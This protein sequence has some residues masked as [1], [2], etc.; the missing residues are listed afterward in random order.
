MDSFAGSFFTLFQTVDNL[1]KTLCIALASSLT[2]PSL[3]AITLLATDFPRN[4]SSSEF[5]TADALLQ[6]ST[7]NFFSGGGN[8]LG[9]N[10]PGAAANLVNAYNDDEELVIDFENEA[11]LSGFHVRWTNTTLTITGLDADPVATVGLSGGSANWSEIRKE[12]TLTLPWD[13]GTERAISFANPEATRG[14]NLTFQFSGVQATFTQ[15]EYEEEVLPLPEPWVH[16]SFDD[17]TVTGTSLTDL[18]SNGHTGTL[19][20]S[21]SSPT[22]SLSGLFGEAFGF[23]GDDDPDGVV[24]IPAGIVPSGASAR[25]FSLWFN[26]ASSVGQSKLFGY[27]SSAAGKAFDIGLEG[28]GVRLRHFGGFVTFGSGLDFD[29]VDAGWH[30]LAVRVNEGA[31]TFADVELFLD[32]S[33]ILPQSGG[34]TSVV[35]DTASALFALGSSATPGAAQGFDGLLDEFRIYNSALQFGQIRDLAEAPPRPAILTFQASPQ[36]RVPANSSVTLSWT[37]ENTTSLILDPGGIDVTGQTSLVVTPSEKTTYTLTASDN[38]P[39]SASQALTVA[40]GEEPFPN[41]IVFFLDDFSWSDWEQNGAS[42]GSVFH[43]TPNMNRMASEGVYCSNGY[44]AT[45]VCSPTRG[46]LMSGQA[47][48]LNKVTDWISGSGDNGQTVREAEWLQNLPTDLPNWPRTLADCGYRSIHVGK[49]HLGETDHPSS[50][51]LNHG[52]Q[53][54]I[55]G[56]RF[57]TPPAPERYFASANGFSALPNLGP[58]I[59]PQGSYLTDVLTEQAVA[60]IQDAASSNTAFAMYFSHYAVHTPI[61]APAATVAKYQAKLDNNPGMDWQGHT[62]PTYAAMVEHIDL[63]LGA[64]LDTLQDPDGD[65]LTDDS[66]AENTLVILTAD[67]GG[68]MSVTSNRPLRNG[69][70]GNYDGGV[71]E[72]WIFWQPGNLAPRVEEEPII[73]YDL[74]PTILSKAGITTPDNHSVSGQDLNA[75][76][77]GDSFERSRP[78][79][80]HY[81]HWSPSSQ[82][83]SPFSAIRHGDWKLIYTYADKSWQLYN[84]SSNIGETNNLIATESDRHKVLSWLLAEQLEEL[85]ANYPRNLTSLAEEPPIPLVT[86][87]DDSDGDGQSDL[88]EAIQGT[89]PSDSSSYFSPFIEFDDNGIF[90]NFSPASERDYS[91]LAS[92]TLLPESWQLI[93]D[94]LPL[95]DPDEMG[96]RRFYQIRTS[97]RY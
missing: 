55:G 72:P 68:L 88:D 96:D 6:F 97:I 9:D 87:E 51:P 3:Q 75:L 2:I 53:V 77:L 67:N 65:P 35:L 70:G 63:S 66:I 90:F 95:R 25:T 48:A 13:G 92:E 32:G 38:V 5:A 47:P 64:I 91:L 21:L 82:I 60:Q 58:D 33:R 43:E 74:F 15:F 26:Q 29:G 78:I 83:G 50:D 49:W 41:I 52:F 45:P 4:S 59:A 94:T 89:N 62:N 20:P 54:N 34:A 27:G 73:T 12:L 56:N 46:A 81:P 40:T 7:T 19:I 14:A 17:D 39:L 18:S 44:A 71:R 24:T 1:M 69:K 8:F 28:D 37:T 10:G 85:E 36:N 86:P 22:T 16:Y 61:Q 93:D 79:T 23:L 76:L 42:T 57:G 80:I 11:Q 31:I 30:H 84:L